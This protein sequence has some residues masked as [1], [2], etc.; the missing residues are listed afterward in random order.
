MRR[1]LSRLGLVGIVMGGAIALSVVEASATAGGSAYDVPSVV[2]TNPDPMVVETAITAQEATLDVGGGVMADMQT[3]NGS[4]PGPEF[5]L[6]VGQRVIVH[7]ENQL[8]DEATGIH[9]HGIELQNQMDGTPLTQDQVAPGDSYTYDF[10]VTRPGVFWYH[11]HHQFSSNQVFKGMYGSII[12]EDPNDAALVADDTLP[13]IGDTH[14]FVLSSTTVCKAPGSNDTATYDPSLPW[15]GGGPLP[16]QPGPTPFTLC[17]GSPV[18]HFGDPLPAGEV[19][20]EGAIPNVSLPGTRVNEGQTVLVNGMNVGGRGGDPSSPGSLDAG[21]LTLAVQPGQ[22][23]RL[24]VINAATTRFFRLRLTLSDGTLVPLIRVG[25][26]GGL[27]DSALLPGGTLTLDQ[28]APGELLLDPGDRDD[29]VAAFP[30]TASGVATL[31]TLDME[32]TGQGFANIPTVPVAHFDV[33]GSAV[34]PAYSIT[35]GTPLRSATGDLVEVLPAPTDV[36]IDPSTLAPAKPGMASSDIKLTVSGGP[37]IDGVAGHHDYTTYYGSHPAPVS[38]RYAKVGDLLEL[39]ATNQTAAHHPFHLHGFSIQPLTMANCDGPVTGFTFPRVEFQDNIDVPPGCT[40]TFR[41][42]IDD[43][44]HTDGVTPGGALGRWMFHCHIFFH[45]DRGMVSELIVTDEDGNERPFIDVDDVSISGTEGDLLQ[46]TGVWLDP[47]SD[48]VTLTASLG[49]A[50]AHGDGTWTWTWSD[51]DGPFSG[52]VYVTATDANGATGQVAFEVDV[53]NVAPSVDLDPEQVEAILE[54]ETLEIAASFSDPGVDEPY[55]ATIDFGTGN[56]P[57]V[58]T[59]NVTSTDQPQGGT[60][61]GS[62]TYGDDGTFTVTVS[63]TDDDGATGQASFV[64]TVDNVDP[65]VTVDGGSVVIGEVGDPIHVGGRITDPG[66]D[67]ITS[68]WHADDGSP[69]ELQVSLVNPPGTDPYPSPSVQPRDVQH[70]FDRVFDEGCVQMLTFSATDDDG[71][72]DEVS[73]WVVLVGDDEEPQRAGY[74]KNEYRPIRSRDHTDAELECFLEIT[75]LL[76]DVFDDTQPLTTLSDGFDIL[77]P[78]HDHDLI[79]RLDRELLMAW[80][81]LASGSIGWDEMVDTDKD[82][83]ADTAFGDLLTAV[84]AVRLD[85]SS[86]PAELTEAQRVLERINKT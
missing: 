78:A 15:A 58:A 22:G 3:F 63:V 64:V 71:G 19:H 42:R 72:S 79:Q 62:F 21:A 47:E 41:V 51:T 39:S 25:G 5:R 83:V 50:V 23:I 46:M 40:L 37:S 35:D 70:D 32:R 84:E 44:A 11:P 65:L 29:V 57:Q 33:A 31:W 77:S 61:G 1:L 45:H 4:V 75:R 85:A 76:S 49:T 67:D 38:A 52:F 16:V 59:V 73:V 34:V 81:N 68:T 69:D 17:E 56:G 82:K 55:S 30:D 8:S 12:V 26:E 86:T 2:D 74:W 60:V 9:W 6:T 13:A 14:T 36:L 54:G 43:R 10:V 80:L 18:D 20:P 53:A 27:L 7:F 66:S 24:Q 48:D 28:L